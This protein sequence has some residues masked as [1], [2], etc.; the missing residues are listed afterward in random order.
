MGYDGWPI[1]KA[2]AMWRNSNATIWTPLK[3]HFKGL[4]WPEFRGFELMIVL[5]S[6]QYR[7]WC[8]ELSKQGHWNLLRL[9]LPQTGFLHILWRNADV[10]SMTYEECRMKYGV[11]SMEYEVYRMKFEVSNNACTL[12]LLNTYL[13]P[14]IMHLWRYTHFV[15]NQSRYL[16][17]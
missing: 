16:G 13:S 5:V 6:Y 10:W 14:L 12:K 11:W 1:P 4:L 2:I 3:C 9:T 8:V 7:V 15:L 17:C